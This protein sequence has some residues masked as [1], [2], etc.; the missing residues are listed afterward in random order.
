MPSAPQFSQTDKLAFVP[1]TIYFFNTRDITFEKENY[2]II[3]DAAQS[4]FTNTN[5]LSSSDVLLLSFYPT[6]LSN[7]ISGGAVLTN[8]ENFY[9]KLID[10]V[11]YT[12]QLKY[13][14]KKRYNFAMNNIIKY[15]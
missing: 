14:G 2:F 8:D 3:E 9:K 5:C 11:S 10:K 6:K 7:G 12:N 13:D 1:S 15:Y 4:F